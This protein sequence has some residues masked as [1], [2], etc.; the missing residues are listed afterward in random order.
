[1][2]HPYYLLKGS[3][4]DVWFQGIFL[5]LTLLLVGILIGAK[6]KDRENKMDLEQEKFEFEDIDYNQR[7]LEQLE[8]QVK[9]Q[10]EHLQ[11][12]KGERL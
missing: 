1:M 7:E 8:L 6:L 12:L 10:R 4:S 2:E 9:H 3:L 5:A 11:K